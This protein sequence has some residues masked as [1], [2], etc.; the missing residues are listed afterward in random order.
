M[1]FIVIQ[2]DTSKPT[3]PNTHSGYYLPVLFVND[4]WILKDHLTPINETVK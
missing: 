4:F 2:L 1:R 3:D